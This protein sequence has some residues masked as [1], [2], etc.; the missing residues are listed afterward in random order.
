MKTD[1][2]NIDQGNL[3]SGG[4][5]VLSSRKGLLHDLV[6][7]NFFKKLLV[8]TVI[9]APL[10]CYLPSD[11]YFYLGYYSTLNL[12]IA[13]SVFT[14]TGWP[15]YLFK[16][17]ILFSTLAAI[18]SVIITGGML[19]TG[20]YHSILATNTME[21]FGYFSL[22]NWTL[23]T[24]SVLLFILCA[25]WFFTMRISVGRS[26][27]LMLWLGATFLIF[28]LPGY[29]YFVDPVYAEDV[30]RDPTNSLYA[31]MDMPTYNLFKVSAL[32]HRERYLSRQ[33]YGDKLP[34]HIVEIPIDTMP[35]H[36]IIVIVGESSQ[37]DAYSIYGETVNTSP[38]MK[39]RLR[40]D[41]N[42]FK[43][44]RVQSPAP[45]TRESVA[46][47]LSFT[48]SKTSLKEGL[49]YDTLLSVMSRLGYRTSW[50]TTQELFTRWD[51]FS[52]KIA[53]SADTIIHKSQDG[54]PWTDSAAIDTAIK[55]LEKPHASFIV[56]HLSG[57]H[58]DYRI[59]NNLPIPEESILAITGQISAGS[60]LNDDKFF[61]FASIH[62]TDTLLD[63]VFEH[64][65]ESA[66]PDMAL[67]FPDHGEVI[68]KGHG[69][70]P[71]NVN[72]ELGIPLVIQGEL[73]KNLREEIDNFRDLRFDT[74][75][76]SY[77]PEVLIN[78]LG[79]HAIRTKDVD[80]LSFFSIQG[81]PAEVQ[82]S[83]Y[84]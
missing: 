52:A 41:Q 66:A 31:I 58:S 46:R 67:Y 48:N 78:T 22:V 64:V 75:N 55:E 17:L 24:A 62:H 23:V 10:L 14:L 83:H 50:I 59:R 65:S 71:V 30:A 39:K 32:A 19:S 5:Y 72:E 56:V 69:L 18:L 9:L 12:L 8:V 33:P 27:R 35:L 70:I 79:G 28:A 16:S 53:N 51:T 80:I 54:D 60:R 26:Q 45:N 1:N 38:T 42:F 2:L 77:L 34:G 74:F 37:R 25:Y 11:N 76:T 84:E 29:K 47:S 13:I 57:E 7:N 49:S 36:D 4:S 3:H 20:A 81:I 6:K 21:V 63:R 43:I 68:G 61:Y 40:H 82:A 44:N 73:G 15:G